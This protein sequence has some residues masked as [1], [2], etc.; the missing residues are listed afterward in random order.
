MSLIFGRD[1]MKF[2]SQT[3]ILTI[4][5]GLAFITLLAFQIGVR[6]QPKVE[7]FDGQ[8]AYADVLYQV[9]LGPRIPGSQAH[10]QTGDWIVSELE[11]I[12]WNVEVQET[13]YNGHPIRNIVAKRGA[14]GKW[15]IL[16]AHYDSR[17]EASQE[18]NLEDQAKPVPGANDGASGVAVLL[19]LAR[20]LPEKQGQQVWLFFIDAED[21]GH[22][23]GWEWIEGSTA[24][25]QSLEGQP[26][27]VVIVDMIGDANLNIYKEKNSD[28]FLTN[29]IWQT[30]A[31]LGYDDVFIDEYKY[32]ILDDH[33]PFIRRGIPAVDI[34][35]FDYP[36]W[37]TLE[38]TA[39][40][41]SPESLE[42]IGR[43][44]AQWIADF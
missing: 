5:L 29:Q 2:Q 26:N 10:S 25:A 21:Q 19:E 37:H 41:V 30:A 42:I 4:L 33:L 14:T 13:T 15:I 11:E 7:P 24:F 36:H 32:Q 18:T 39:D 28:V 20:T 8:R 35:D 38:D 12:G 22:L 3:R 40:K 6:I 1:T 27:A 23:P 34:I 17:Q 31:G 44:L 16:G 9:S 43:T